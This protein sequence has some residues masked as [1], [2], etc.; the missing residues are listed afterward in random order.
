MR[1]HA[2]ERSRSRLRIGEL[3]AR[4]GKS[5]HAIRWYESQ[6][7][8]PGVRRD[9]GGRRVYSEHHVGWLELLGR[10]RCTGMSIKDMHRYTAL[11][12]EGTD[13]LDQRQRLLQTHRLQ[14]EEHIA[15]WNHALEMIDRKI[16]FYA[17]WIES[18]S[19]PTADWLSEERTKAMEPCVQSGESET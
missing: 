4:S 15:E 6:G 7:L 16:G 19:M 10:L 9:T 14:V 8:M 11:V 18:G 3:A 1:Q 12:E 17:H 2:A 5:V 13:T